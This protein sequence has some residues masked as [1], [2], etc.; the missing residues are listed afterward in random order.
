MDIK[1][2]VYNS[3]KYKSIGLVCA[4][5]VIENG[6]VLLMK[7]KDDDKWKTLG[8]KLKTT[9]SLIEC[10]KRE[11]VEEIKQEVSIVDETPIC[12]VEDINDSLVVI[13]Y[14]SCKLSSKVEV[15]VSDD[16]EIIGWFD[17]DNLPANLFSSTRIAVGHFKKITNN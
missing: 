6:K 2:P 17:V 9:E 14:F 8:G 11:S 16:D 12:S 13:F 3:E 15:E 5:I 7:A 4:A 1:L 10:I